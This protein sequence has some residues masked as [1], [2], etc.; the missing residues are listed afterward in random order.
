M[1]KK[2]TLAIL[3]ELGSNY[4][5][6]AKKM[7]DKNKFNIL[8]NTWYECLKD[9]T[10]AQVSRAVKEFI[11]T[12]RFQ[13]TINEIRE[14]TTRPEQVDPLK[15][16]NEA[17]KMISNGYYMTQEEYETHSDIVKKFFGSV[18]QVKALSQVDVETINTVTKGQFL[19]QI[20]AIQERK[21]NQDMLPVEMQEQIKKI[22]GGN[23]GLL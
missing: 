19:K 18:N 12:S 20:T 15:Y 9:L 2:E 8:L 17:Y 10:Y 14:K 6:F 21:K 13:P 16:W 1:D 5:F 7:E 11:L 23:I 4:D 3:T 22:G